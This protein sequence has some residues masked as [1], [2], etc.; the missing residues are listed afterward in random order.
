[1][2]RLDGFFGGQH[3]TI[4]SKDAEPVVFDRDTI[5]S[6]RDEGG[7]PV[8][9]DGDDGPRIDRTR[10]R[11]ARFSSISVAGPLFVGTMRSHEILT[12][13]LRSIRAIQA[14][15]PNAL[16]TVLAIVIP[17]VVLPLFAFAIFVPVC[18]STKCFG[19]MW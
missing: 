14:K 12:I 3:R 7:A 10:E 19:T 8:W 18:Q 9:V 15:K 2:Q 4:E 1:M 6:F 17:C 16:T 13:D 11:E 5:L